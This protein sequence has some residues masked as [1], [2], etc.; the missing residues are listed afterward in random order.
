MRKV[1]EKLT[2]DIFY[3]SL[4]TWVIYFILELL[5][6]GLVSNYFDLNLLLIFVI[7]FAI[8][9]SFLNYDFGR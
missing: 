5:K 7:V 6:E 8:I 1:I 2:D 4:L 9:N 3:I